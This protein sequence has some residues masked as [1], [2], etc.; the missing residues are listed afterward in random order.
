M[1][2]RAELFSRGMASQLSSWQCPS[3]AVCNPCGTRS[4]S[5]D[6][7]GHD[8]GGWEHIACRRVP[9]M[10][11]RGRGVSVAMRHRRTYDMDGNEF[12]GIWRSDMDISRMGVVTNIHIVRSLRAMPVMCVLT[13]VFVHAQTDLGIEGACVNAARDMFRHVHWACE[14]HAF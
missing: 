10:P 14:L 12:R 1:A 5:G 6:S 9:R 4:G 13:A 3:G 11:V 8:G 7:W 2:L